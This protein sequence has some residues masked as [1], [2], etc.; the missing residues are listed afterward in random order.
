DE[1]A[2]PAGREAGIGGRDQERRLRL[3]STHGVEGAVR[4]GLVRKT[5]LVWERPNERLD[6][7]G[8]VPRDHYEAVDP[9]CGEFVEERHDHGLAVDRQHGLRPVVRE[10]PQ[11]LAAAGGEHHRLYRRSCSASSRIAAATAAFDAFGT[12]R[13]PA[14]VTRTTS[15]SGASKPMSARETSL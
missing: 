13:S 10:R 7:L 4:F 6:L 14:R 2:E 12:R 3:G 1:A 9:C 8:K 15:F 5:E 11:A